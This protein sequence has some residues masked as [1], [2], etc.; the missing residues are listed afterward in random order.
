[1]RSL[2]T[3][4]TQAVNQRCD[5]AMYETFWL[6][7][8]TDAKSAATD[9]WSLDHGIVNTCRTNPAALLAGWVALPLT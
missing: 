2:P 3:A 8:E 7:F 5:N 1:M 9:V 6:L 4:M